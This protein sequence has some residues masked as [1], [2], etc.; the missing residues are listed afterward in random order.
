MTLYEDFKYW[1][2]LPKFQGVDIP[3]REFSAVEITQRNGSNAGWP[4]P[5]KDVQYWVELENGWA[6]GIITPRKK[7]ATF[8]FYRMG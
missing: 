5:E 3:A 8:P 4:G 6:V 7:P 1:W 2:N